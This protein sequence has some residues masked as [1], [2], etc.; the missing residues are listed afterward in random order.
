MKNL[1]LCLGV[2]S[3]TASPWLFG[4]IIEEKPGKEYVVTKT[5]VVGKKLVEVLDENGDPLE[6][7]RLK[8]AGISY[9]KDDVFGALR[10]TVLLRNSNVKF[11]V[12]KA[13]VQAFF[14]HLVLTTK[15]PAL[16]IKWDEPEFSYYSGDSGTVEAERQME[17][18]SKLAEPLKGMELTAD[19]TL[20][21]IFRYDEVRQNTAKIGPAG[22][23]QEVPASARAGAWWKIKIT[24]KELPGFVFQNNAYV[25]LKKWQRMSTSENWT[26]EKSLDNE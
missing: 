12:D 1:M 17:E 6:L 18:F 20:K 13:F 23:P 14:A 19:V 26:V 4:K 11:R 5:K 7:F 8:R 25:E 22:V 24:F 16:A 21:D 15:E 10:S 2:L 9:F 3:L